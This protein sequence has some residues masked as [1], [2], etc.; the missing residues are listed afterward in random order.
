M[1]RSLILFLGLISPTILLA[2][3][4]QELIRETLNQ[5]IEGTVYN[6]PQKV[7]EVFYPDTRMF[8]HNG[9]DTA[10]VVS[11]ETYASWYSRR[12]PGTQNKRINEIKS[13]EVVG[14]V[15]YAKLQVD[16]PAFGNRYSDLMLLK[17]IQGAW[18]IVGKATSATPIPRTA[19]ELRAK[20]VKETVLT[21]L[22]KPWSMAF[23]T[24]QEVLI[25]E[26][27]GDLIWA[28]LE[29]KARK[30]IEGLP[31]DVARKIRIDTSKHAFGI[32]PPSAHGLE[33]SFNAG[34]F[35]VL[36]DPDFEKNAWVYLSYAAENDKKESTTKVIRGK[37]NGMR[38]TSV[39]V[40]FE[41]APYSHGLFHY[42]GGM[43]FGPDGKLYITIGERNLF[44]KNNP[45]LPL[46]QDMLDK[47]GK[48]I[49]LNPDGSI[50]KDNPVF[51]ER[52]VPGLFAL[53][54]RA[55]QGLTIRPGT[56]DIWFSEH[57]TIQ[58][59]ELNILKPGVNYGWP[60]KTSGRYR[61]SDYHPQVPDGLVFED[62]VYFWDK[63]V[64]PTGLAFYAGREFPDWNGNLI[65]PGLS[66]GS[67]WRMEIENDQVTAAEELYIDDRVRLRKVVVSPRGQLYLLTDE[68]NGKIIRVKNAAR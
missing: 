43:I 11:S 48:V 22:N 7:R 62:P 19:A 34:W 55:S 27:D 40:L 47:R 41:A 65:V 23:L 8:L 59:D 45:S 31:G 38:L 35:Q 9:A 21:G 39:E 50:P 2:Q 54:I 15:A 63:T 52:S 3:T 36:L 13:V 29:T 44:E 61:T 5:F 53:G 10:W 51:Q 64:A 16:V 18:K 17:K 1:I 68:E 49:R 42:G 30:V 4:D 57:G 28:N 60:Y 66:K 67:L 32:F 6:Y 37:L 24:E 12:T 26:K 56:E 14:D 25:T 46:A 33:R 58:G 20:P